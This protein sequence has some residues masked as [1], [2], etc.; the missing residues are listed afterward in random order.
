MESRIN[1]NSKGKTWIRKKKHE[2][3]EGW[4]ARQI[5]YDTA[6]PD[7]NTPDWQYERKLET[8]CASDDNDE[9]ELQHED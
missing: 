9:G 8:Q 2:I 6:I 7:S 4:T 3:L 1:I 5:C